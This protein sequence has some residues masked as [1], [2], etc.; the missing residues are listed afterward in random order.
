MEKSDV[1]MGKSRIQRQ[2]ADF[3]DLKE[4]GQDMVFHCLH[5]VQQ[6]DDDTA[7]RALLGPLMG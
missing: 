1:D 5:L 4:L 6:I 3:E 2:C 7:W